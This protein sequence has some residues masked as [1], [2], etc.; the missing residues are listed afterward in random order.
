MAH[1][2]SFDRPI[3]HAFLAQYLNFEDPY[4]PTPPASGFATVTP[5][6]APIYTVRKFIALCEE[7]FDHFPVFD[8]TLR[9]IEL[10]NRE[11]SQML[12]NPPKFS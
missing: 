9:L 1:W 8:E 4:S 2:R 7:I 5:T 3:Y 12:R 6:V 10:C 11:N